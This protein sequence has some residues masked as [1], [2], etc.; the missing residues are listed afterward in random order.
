MLN[1][2]KVLDLSRVLAGPLCS[3]MLGDLGARVIKIERPGSG[4]DT[5]GWGPPFDERGESA[6][7][8]AV[9]RNKLSVA[10]DLRLAAD[11]VLI[12]RL[13]AQADVV[14]ENFLPGALAR[15]GLDPDAI[16]ARHPS[17][18]WCTI[19]GFP[20]H[21]AR[22]GYDFVV[23]AECGWMAI[24]GE[25]EGAAM[26]H[27]VA[28]VDLVAGKDAAIGILGALVA[29]A[30]D[31]QGRHVRT[32]LAGSARAALINVAQNALVS[33]RDARRWGNAHANLVPYQLFQAADRA[34]V[35]AL[36]NDSQ[37]A[38]CATALGLPELA[39]DAGL[40]TN[41]GRLGRRDEV[42]RAVSERVRA[43]S[44]SE[45]VDR[46]ARA[47]VPCGMVRGVLEAIGEVGASP[48]TGM[49]SSVGGAVHRAPPRLDEHGAVVR[50]RGWEAFVLPG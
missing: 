16:R 23:Q 31:G 29:R 15:T 14:I 46:L 19:E 21:P 36:G 33:G 13:L 27:G 3:M 45:W 39:A 6:Y 47:G 30:G 44:A 2:I 42:V 37:W 25:P 22:P 18:V 32:S 9:N 40:A 26:K 20:E 5:R 35:I 11:R 7:F 24:T 50:E 10:A 8:L 12:E 49:P 1:S 17:L 34:I 4:D 43:V 48:L 38:A 28:L 41:A